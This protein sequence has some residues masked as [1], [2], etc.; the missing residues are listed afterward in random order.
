MIELR[1]EVT[2]EMFWAAQR[3]VRKRI[4]TDRRESV[5]HRL[6]M[7]LL[8]WLGLVGLFLG[9]QIL[10]PSAEFCA[11]PLIAGVA[12]A[13]LVLVLFS[14]RLRQIYR[15]Y[16]PHPGG[17]FLGNRTL[18]L[19]DLG[20]HHQGPNSSSHFAWEC[21]DRISDDDKHVFIFVDRIA[22]LVVPK[23]SIIAP[24]TTQSFQRF[25]EDR[26]KAKPAPAV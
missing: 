12:T 3:A 25:I 1:Y 23:T 13:A 14:L 6:F 8:I 4:R 22:A 16:S 10:Y 20:L 5:K 9:L 18:V 11:S 15:S 26:I 2:L 7:V 24:H 17:A 21:V 19:D